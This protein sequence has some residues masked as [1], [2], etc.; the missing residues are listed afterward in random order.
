MA[1]P[2]SLRLFQASF[3]GECREQQAPMAV[4]AMF[5]FFLPYSSDT[6][7]GLSS[8]FCPLLELSC[9]AC[10]AQASVCPRLS[11]VAGAGMPNN[12]VWDVA[13]LMPQFC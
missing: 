1:A 7:S 2:R 8:V 11:T 4:V 9:T 12:P 13:G 6:L 5:V 3:V 10:N